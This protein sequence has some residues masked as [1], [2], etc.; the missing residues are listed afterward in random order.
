MIAGKEKAKPLELHNH[1]VTREWKKLSP[2]EHREWEE[3]AV[4]DH[5]EAVRKWA[6]ETV[7]FSEEPEARQK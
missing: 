3:K 2:E 5:K 1:I 4:A 6:E 7:D